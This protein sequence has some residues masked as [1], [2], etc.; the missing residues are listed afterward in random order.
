[1]TAPDRRDVLKA[2]TAVPAAALAFTWTADEA[3]LAADAA[4]R[5]RDQAAA[6]NRAY[7]P[8]FFTAREYTAIVMLSDLILPKDAR[9]ASASEAG[10]PEF[11]DFIVAEQAERQTAMRGGL[12]WL[13]VECLNRFDK[14]FLDSSDVQRRQ[15]LDAIAFPARTAPD[16]IQGARFFTTMRDLVATGFWSSKVG[17]ADLG[18]MGNRPTSWDGPP[19]AVLD[20]LGIT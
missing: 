9:S 12:A 17:V 7:T 2:L 4:G 13:D 6:G 1:M 20:K 10:V 8:K 5:A 15:V 16:L 18:Y 11:I 14:S 3:L 19:Q